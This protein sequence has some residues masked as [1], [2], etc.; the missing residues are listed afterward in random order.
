DGSA[1]AFADMRAPCPELVVGCGCR[2]WL[3]VE[4]VL[5][6]LLKQRI[7]GSAGAEMAGFGRSGPPDQDVNLVE[8]E[9]ALC[10]R[11]RDDASFEVP[12]GPGD[13]ARVRGPVGLQCRGDVG[14]A[15]AWCPVPGLPLVAAQRR[16]RAAV[17]LQLVP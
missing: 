12:V 9:Q 6:V 15:G 10:A 7:D 1:D 17:D 5:R 3:G 2:W 16:E 8:V 13:P 11:R 4:D 14:F